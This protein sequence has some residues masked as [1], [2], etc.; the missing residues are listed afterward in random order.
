MENIFTNVIMRVK[1][2]MER[3]GESAYAF[4]KALEIPQPTLASY[5]SGDRKPSLDFVYRVCKVC[6]CSA[7]Q[8]LGLP[9]SPSEAV[10]ATDEIDDIRRRADSANKSVAAL[11]ESLDALSRR[12]H[13]ARRNRQ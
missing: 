5:M 3:R 6:N 13:G 11:L 9:E 8:I 7:N 10:C 1:E 2:Q 4:A 12:A